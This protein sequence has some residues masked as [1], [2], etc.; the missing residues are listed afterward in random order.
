MNNDYLPTAAANF[1]YSADSM[2]YSHR[3]TSDDLSP[4]PLDPGAEGDEDMENDDDES[5]MGALSSLNS[6]RTIPSAVN[7][8][9][10]NQQTSQVAF[11]DELPLPLNKSIFNDSLP[12]T[13]MDFS[14]QNSIYQ[15]FSTE[16]ELDK[17]L[18]SN[19]TNN[20]N[21]AITAA[22]TARTH[23]QT[24]TATT[25]MGP[26]ISSQA[27]NQNTMDYKNQP[28]LGQGN[29]LPFIPNTVATKLVL[30]E[31][32][33]SYNSASALPS[34]SFSTPSVFPMTTSSNDGSRRSST[35]QS[36][37]AHSQSTIRRSSAPSTR[38]STSSSPSSSSS[39]ASSGSV[40]KSAFLK[41][42]T[43]RTDEERKRRNRV[44]A[45]RSRDL[46]NQ[47]YRE[48]LNK[49]KDLEHRVEVI[50]KHNQA[51]KL[52]NQRLEFLLKEIRQKLAL[53]G[54]SDRDVFA[55]LQNSS[56]TRIKKEKY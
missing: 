32:N 23:S 21:S 56:R 16:Y 4:P 30:P 1:E 43:V 6:F 13:N 45:K 33:F 26:F 9:P 40:T 38:S 17:I 2:T 24:V 42:E 14:L 11:A 53:H 7:N 39:S 34:R 49:N 29:V 55:K 41:N 47:K 10:S 54:I 48:S 27:L 5:D 22:Q 3:I 36:S 37:S 50:T 18:N 20:M 19:N 31:P 28:V 44:Y 25:A 46:K 35:R 8:S 51:L 12:I 15:T 52:E